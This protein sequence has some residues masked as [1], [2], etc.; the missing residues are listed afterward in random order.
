M[1]IVMLIVVICG[2][3][4]IAVH[5]WRYG[6][7]RASLGHTVIVTRNAAAYIEQFFY[8]QS[9]SGWGHLGADELIVL[10]IGSTDDTVRI[11]ERWLRY[12]GPIALIVMAR[13]WHEALGWLAKRQGN[14]HPLLKTTIQR[15]SFCGRAKGVVTDSITVLKYGE[16]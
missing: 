5:D 11:S 14:T 12:R 13:D 9:W 8:E 6:T 15:P 3:M 10:D 1:E 4:F 2:A 16:V 7:H